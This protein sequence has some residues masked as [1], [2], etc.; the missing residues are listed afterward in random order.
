MSRVSLVI[1][2]GQFDAGFDQIK[3]LPRCLDAGFRLFL[4]CVKYIDDAFEPKQINAAVGVAVVIVHDFKHTGP[5]SLERFCAPRL[6]AGLSISQ[7]GAHIAS[8]FGWK[9][10]HLLL[11]V[12][13]P[14]AWFHAHFPRIY[15]F[16]YKKSILVESE[17][18]SKFIN[19][20]EEDEMPTDQDL[21]DIELSDLESGTQPE[22][23]GDDSG[24]NASFKEK[25]IK[26]FGPITGGLDPAR[27]NKQKM[28]RIWDFGSQEMYKPGQKGPV[29]DPFTEY[30]LFIG[31][32]LDTFT[33]FEDSG[34]STLAQRKVWIATTIDFCLKMQKQAGYLLGISSE[35]KARLSKGLDAAAK[36]DIKKAMQSQIS[37]RGF[38][39]TLSDQEIR[40]IL[41]L[42]Y[43]YDKTYYGGSV[44][45]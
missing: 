20:N 42:K 23:I 25:I 5:K 40:D 30:E 1:R 19:E 13:D 41:V 45:L 38:G 44:V 21:Q 7:G 10:P 32:K 14:S 22:E 27:M 24:K 9:T 33:R 12:T 35:E 17:Y 16:K 15:S 39:K 8:H 31:K 3:I 18:V 36:S 4:E 34:L 29:R 11:C 6:Q 28:A 26:I 43:G 37:N 2:F